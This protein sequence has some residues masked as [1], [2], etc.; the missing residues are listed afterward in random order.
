[1]KPEPLSKIERFR[2]P[3]A[4]GAV[5]IGSRRRVLRAGA[6]GH[7]HHAAGSFGTG[8]SRENGAPSSAINCCVAPRRTIRA[9][10]RRKPAG[11]IR[12]CQPVLARQIPTGDEW[13]HELKWDGYRIIVRREA[14]VVRF[15]SRTGR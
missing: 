15:W 12:P 5:L 9:R 7:S 4:P 8:G 1:M 6:R 10:D 14:V 13:I 11:F 3:W 2:H